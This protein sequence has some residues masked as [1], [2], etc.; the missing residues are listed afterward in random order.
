METSSARELTGV[1]KRDA[2]EEMYGIGLKS[3]N[4]TYQEKAQAYLNY[5]AKNCIE[6]YTKEDGPE[7][8]EIE[9]RA[10]SAE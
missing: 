8:E 2:I 10:E 4:L 5:R 3:Q 7:K 6:P 1:E 9:E